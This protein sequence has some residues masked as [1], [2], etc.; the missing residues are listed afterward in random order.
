MA[1][2]SEIGV[3]KLGELSPTDA[4]TVRAVI[5]RWPVKQRIVASAKHFDTGEAYAQ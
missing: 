2:S 4:L 1:Y 3:P 5:W